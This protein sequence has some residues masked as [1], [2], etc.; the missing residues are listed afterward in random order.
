[1]RPVIWADEGDSIAEAA[2]LLDGM[3]HSCVMVRLATG[4]AIATDHDF[5]A[6]LANASVS[7]QTPLSAIC[8]VPA[9]TVNE[10]TDVGGALIEMV[11]R[12]VHH[13]VVISD[14]GDPVGV[15]RVVDLASAAVRDP[16]LVRHSINRSRS[17]EEL[18]DAASVLPRTVVEMAGMGTP[19]LQVSGILSVVR[20][21]VV[22]RAVQL[23]TTAAPMADVSWLVL[24]SLARREAMPGSDVDTALAWP[25]TLDDRA[26]QLRTNA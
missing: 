24:G 22:Q 10:H 12:G 21:L 20:D 9:V 26:A 25:V 15:V 17:L 13:L 6:S 11:E 3:D 2:R 4:L 8:S 19:A 16:L 18:Q 5:R 1:M 23:T 14:T 7:R